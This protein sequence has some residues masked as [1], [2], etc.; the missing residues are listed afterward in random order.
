V[1]GERKG[2][3]PLA[4]PGIVLAAVLIAALVLVRYADGLVARA[5]SSR[6]AQEQA[7][8]EARLKYSNAGTEKDIITRYLG[9]YRALQELG[10]V[11][12]EQRI[13]WVDSLR[14]ANR[15]AGMFGVEYQVA[16]QAPYPLA[17]EIGGGS[18]PMKHSVMKLTVPLLH[19]GDLMRF[20]RLL[21]AQRSGVFTLNA[22]QLR[23]NSGGDPNSLQP[24]L[25]AE[26]EVSWITVNEDEKKEGKQ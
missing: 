12:G 14:K 21:A 5:K 15:E 16:Q 17:N 10:F 24:R 23:R 25:G 4:I 6:A 9:T 13:N 3:P 11:G 22:C 18:L 8:S 2:L 19:E 7:L 20:F 26:C 1:N